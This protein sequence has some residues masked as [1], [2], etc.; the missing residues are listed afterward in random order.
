M[1]RKKHRLEA[2]LI[3]QKKLALNPI[4]LDVE[5][6]GMEAL[7]EII[8]IAVVDHDASVLVDSFVK[9]IGDISPSAYAVHGITEVMI[10]DAPPWAELWP[11][12]E[13][14]LRGRVVGIYNADFDIRM[15]EQSHQINQMTWQPPYA[16]QF[17]IMKLYAQFHGEWNPSKRSYRWQ[18]LDAA[19][20]QCNINIPNT[21]RAKDDTL[22]AREILYYM[23]DQKG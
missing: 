3:A 10:K 22:L 8:E 15:M 7:D 4:Y 19:R 14:S 9:P 21:H 11:H 17:C 13:E 20:G 5:T 12:V 23:A 16:D 18:K 1:D 6:T 2:I